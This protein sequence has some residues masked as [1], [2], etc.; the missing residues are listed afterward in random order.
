MTMCGL[1]RECVVDLILENESMQCI[2]LNRKGNHEVIPIEGLFLYLQEALNRI[3]YP[4]LTNSIGK[5]GIERIFT[6]SYR[7]SAKHPQLTSKAAIPL[8]PGQGRPS[9]LLFLYR[10]F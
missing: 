10:E 6:M 8:R 3:Q 1:S 7:A 4:F 9:P 2:I 5:P